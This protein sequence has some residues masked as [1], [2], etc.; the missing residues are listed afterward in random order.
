MK[1]KKA[2]LV[3]LLIS[4]ILLP[5]LITAAINSILSRDIELPKNNLKFPRPTGAV[6]RNILENKE[7]NIFKISA[8]QEKSPL[9]IEFIIDPELTKSIPQE[10]IEENIKEVAKQASSIFLTQVGRRLEIGK[11]TFNI[12]PAEEINGQSV[13]GFEILNW[14]GKLAQTT[15]FIVFVTGKEIKSITGESKSGYANVKRHESDYIKSKESTILYNSDIKVIK[16]VLLH[17]LGHNCGATHIDD[18]KTIP[19]AEKIESIMHSKIT[20]ELK[21]DPKSADAIKQNCG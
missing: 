12:Q 19:G 6:P 3:I 14:L 1:M 8:L 10:N 9:T 17:E 20:S 18:D 16:K 7:T 13:F 2:G 4:A 15:D 21:Y 11:V 5:Q